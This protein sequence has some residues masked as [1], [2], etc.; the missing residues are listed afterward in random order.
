MDN[1]E[2]TFPEL[3]LDTT[4]NQQT[5]KL[6]LPEDELTDLDNLEDV[7]RPEDIQPLPERNLEENLSPEEIK[8]VEDFSKKIDITNSSHILQYGVGAQQKM[9]T[10]SESALS[11]VKGKDLGSVGDMITGLVTEIKDFN[12]NEKQGGFLSIFKKPQKQMER[13]QTQYSSVEKNVDRIVVELETHKRTLLKDI[14]MLDKMYDMNL[15]YYKE[16]TLYILAG[17]KK[18][19]DV[20]DN[21]LPALHAK[22]KETGQ[23]QDA[24]A[25]NDLANQC[26][27]FDKKLHD[28]ELTRNISIQMGPQIRLVQS[29]DA[30]MVEKIQSSIVNTIPLWKNQMVLTLGLAHSK[31]AIEAQRKV[32]D[33]TNQ[34]LRENADTLKTSTVEAAKES[35]RGIVDMETLKH[36]NQALIETLDDVLKIQQEGYQKRRQAETELQL[37]E[38]QLKEKL[39]EVKDVTTTPDNQNN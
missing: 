11:A 33:V 20:Y 5:P 2:N 10:F 29:N 36:T 21:E 1:N 4:E 30:M 3:S 34:L 6:V 7:A 39:L 15:N 16:L 38:N 27:R 37:I 24:Q 22:A 18:L 26:N 13:I 19:Q 35:E 28:L 9:V 23:P 32:T 17:K 25:A 14:T 8:L 31:S 12:P